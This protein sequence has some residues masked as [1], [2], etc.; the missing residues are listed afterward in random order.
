MLRADDVI[1]VPCRRRRRMARKRAA[2]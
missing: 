2:D 1:R